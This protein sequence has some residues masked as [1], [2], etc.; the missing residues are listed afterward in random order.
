MG[1]NR[2]EMRNFALKNCRFFFVSPLFAFGKLIQCQHNRDAV[3][4]HNSSL[5]FLFMS[6]LSVARS[7]LIDFHKEVNTKKNQHN[8]HKYIADQRVTSTK[9]LAPSFTF[10]SMQLFFHLLFSLLVLL[11]LSS[12]HHQ[13]QHHH[14]RRFKRFVL[15][16][17]TCFIWFGIEPFLHEKK[18]NVFCKSDA[19]SMLR[20]PFDAVHAVSTSESQETMD[21]F[22]TSMI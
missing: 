18:K 4:S 11:V 3:F 21:L 13:H 17:L 22:R 12:N 1:G 15:F 8:K 16:Y 2:W 9:S 19:C 10:T 20:S 7:V 14:H 5:F 6:K